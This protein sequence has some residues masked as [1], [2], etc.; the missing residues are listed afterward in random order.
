[1]TSHKTDI[2]RK[3]IKEPLE[4][5]DPESDQMSEV[6]GF[7][8]SKVECICPRCGKMHIMKIRW[9]GRGVPRKFCESCRDRDTPFDQDD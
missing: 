4:D 2:F 8:K 5:A 6:E 7:S 9:I 3:H 1:M